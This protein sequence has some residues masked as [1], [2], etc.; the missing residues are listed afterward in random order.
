M[1]RN[2]PEEEI[3]NLQVFRV[4]DVF[5]PF[6]P[7]KRA[8]RGQQTYVKLL[9]GEESAYL[10]VGPH[11][12]MRAEV[13]QGLMRLVN[14]GWSVEGE[15]HVTFDGRVE[16]GTDPYVYR[17][18]LVLELGKGL[19]P[20]V[21]PQNGTPVLSRLDQVREEVAREVGMVTPNIRVV[22]NMSLEANHYIIRIKDAP[23]A[24]GEVFL[25]RLLVVGPLELL[26]QL[27]G[28]TTVEPVHRMSA[29]WIESA[30]KERAE[31][32]G[33]LVLG[34]LAVL[35]THVKAVVLAACPDLLGLQET[36]DLINRLR[37]THPVV[38]EDFLQ[39]RVALRRIRRV[40]QDLLS[41]RVPIRD[42]VTILEVCGDVL[43]ELDD[44]ES[45]VELCR[46]QLSRQICSIY[47][48]PE[49]VLRCMALGP[50]TESIFD[51]VLE[52]EDDLAAQTLADYADQLI[53]AVKK[54]R[55]AHGF[56]N[57]LVTDPPTRPLV[58]K[59]LK[60]AFPELGILSTAE[61]V[62]G[63]RVEVCETVEMASVA[64]PAIRDF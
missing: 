53:S 6:A 2:R 32:T 45:V 4:G 48:N 8:E 64:P 63:I 21:D 46:Q 30:H 22:D 5:E 38:V 20:L 55:E 1:A 19:L 41:E 43:E 37:H 18:P 34:P 57:V 60:R 9:K 44:T 52:E 62:S 50:E 14:D 51:K 31:A 29:K 23:M 61:L 33:C 7:W 42:L 56:P 15:L 47:V 28:W 12:N 49:G 27:E 10:F 16:P 36:H 25:D 11:F 58:K 3:Q 40:L 59:F 13:Q 39:N 54:S 26:G 17:D 35:V 24:R